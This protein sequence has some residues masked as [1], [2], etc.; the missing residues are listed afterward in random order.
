MTTS[1]AL[2]SVLFVTILTLGILVFAF[3]MFLVAII[4]IIAAVIVIVGWWW[5]WW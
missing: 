2:V 3:K 1:F 4:I 5:W